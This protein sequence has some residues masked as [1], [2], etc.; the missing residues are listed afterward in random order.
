MRLRASSGEEWLFV[1]RGSTAIPIM[2]LDTH[3]RGIVP[4]AMRPLRHS[5]G[6]GSTAVSWLVLPPDADASKPLPLVVV[7][8][9]GQVYGKTPPAD[10][11]VDGERFYTSAQL[12]AARGFAVLLPSLPMPPILPDSGFAFA[13]A[14]K[15]AI[16]AALATGRC[17]PARIG[18]WGHSYGGYA[19]A[20]AAAQTSRFAGVVASS[21]LYDL[22]GTI[23]TFGPVS[24]A[25]PERGL[26]IASRYAWAEEG[27]GR[28][29]A[30]PW[31]A[32]SR[33]IANSPVYIADRITTPIL[34]TAAD[35]D[36]SPMGQ[37]EQL[38]SALFRQ[39]KD[40]QLVTYWGEGHVIASPTNVRDYYDRVAAFFARTL[41]GE[42]TGSQP[43][44]P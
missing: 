1:V 30:P 5:L 40:A 10:Q 3:M 11:Q 25:M 28:M 9:P 38:F 18:L 26:P 12:L 14:L 19:V 41:A 44:A 35:Q 22:A 42:H 36:V 8:Y 15:P 33:Y 16:A 31:V 39:G 7:P 29:G 32:P 2:T 13:D 23:G 37:A 27:Q 21:G 6:D 20:M 17:D 43:V 4:A 24:R 34:I